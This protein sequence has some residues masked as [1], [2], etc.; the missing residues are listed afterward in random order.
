MI[1]LEKKSYYNMIV[2]CGFVIKLHFDYAP[3]LHVARRVIGAGW[4]LQWGV[5]VGVGGWLWARERGKAARARGGAV[6]GEES[7]VQT[8]LGPGGQKRK[9]VT[10]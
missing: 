7:L 1:V 9:G 5:G 10:S 4:R 2:I 6:R 3:V 8:S